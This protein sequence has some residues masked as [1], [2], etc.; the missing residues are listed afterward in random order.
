M[1]RIGALFLGDQILIILGIDF[2]SEKDAPR[3]AF[4]EPK[5]DQN[6]TKIEVENEDEK[7]MLLEGP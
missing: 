3:G 1:E 7:M 4:C 2:G 6:R 5:W